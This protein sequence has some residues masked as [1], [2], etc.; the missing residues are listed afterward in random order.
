MKHELHLQR[1]IGCLPARWAARMA[2]VDQ[3]NLDKLFSRPQIVR[4]PDAFRAQ[5]VELTGT[6]ADLVRLDYDD[7]DDD[8]DI[9]GDPLP[10]MEMVDGVAII[11][12]QGVVSSGLPKLF[13]KFGYL[14]LG[15]V[16]DDIDAAMADTNCQAIVLAVNSPGGMLSGLPEFANK[17]AAI[18]AGGEKKIAARIDGLGCSAAYYA[19]AG[20]NVISAGISSELVNIGVY[21]AVYNSKKAFEMFGYSVEVIKSGKY[22]AA[23]LPGTDLT[24]DQRKEM[25]DGVNKLGAMFRAHVSAHRP[26]AAA[27]DM[28]GQCFFGDDAMAKGFSDDDSPTMDDFLAGFSAYLKPK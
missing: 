24:D 21:Q 18:A 15:N 25:T 4:D 16:A 28:Q 27:D 12:M 22:K 1:W 6:S 23:G 20:C 17:V 2:V 11:P 26:G 5:T 14:D 7:D 10:E 3:F 13:Q 19:I 8:T 9:W